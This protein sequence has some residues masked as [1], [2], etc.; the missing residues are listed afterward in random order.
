MS[1]SLLDEH[2][3]V[4]KSC[5]G[6]LKKPEVLLGQSDKCFDL[7]GSHILVQVLEDLSYYA[8][9]LIVNFDLPL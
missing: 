5:K 2:D 9:Y 8:I 1:V 7:R 4:K 6:S 3:F